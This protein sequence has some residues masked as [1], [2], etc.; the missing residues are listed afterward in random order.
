MKSSEAIAMR[1]AGRS[2]P[3]HRAASYGRG[4]RHSRL[5]VVRPPR[6]RPRRRLGRIPFL[7]ASFVVVGLLM[8]GVVTVQAILS[9]TSFRMRQLES[10]GIHLRQDYGHLKLEVARLS[11]PGRIVQ[12]AKRLG[13]RLPDQVRTLPVDGPPPTAATPSGGSNPSFA[14]KGVLGEEP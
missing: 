2:A 6:P 3:A 5:R 9:Q 7:I 1:R 8:F 4:G 12:E 11:A 14:L 10:R 13:L